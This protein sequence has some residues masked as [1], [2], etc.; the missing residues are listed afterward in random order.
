MKQGDPGDEFFIIVKGTV[1]VSSKRQRDRQTERH[2]DR[3]TAR[4]TERQ[5]DTLS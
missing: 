5:K 2:T 4:K 3:Q 1:I